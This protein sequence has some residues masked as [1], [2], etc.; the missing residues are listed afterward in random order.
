MN[1]I[2]RIG[3]IV[4]FHRKRAGLTQKQLANLAGVRK[5]AVFDIEKGK[6]TIRMN[7]LLAIIS[8]LNISLNMLHYFLTLFTTNIS[9]H[10]YIL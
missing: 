9:N 4:R 7:T 8:V 5:T 6:I 3:D 2:E 10:Y 1:N